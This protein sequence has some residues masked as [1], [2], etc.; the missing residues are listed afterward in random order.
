[1]Q[2]AKKIRPYV[3]VLGMDEKGKQLL[4]KMSKANPKLDI[5][6]S[7]KNLQ[8]IIIINLLKKC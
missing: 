4:S 8:K 3:R 2:I 7:V 6:T 1:M 5:V